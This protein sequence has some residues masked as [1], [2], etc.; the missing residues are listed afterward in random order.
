MIFTLATNLT[1]KSAVTAGWK[2]TE[3]L[4]VL[5]SVYDLKVLTMKY[6]RIRSGNV[7]SAIF[8]QNREGIEKRK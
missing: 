6:S 1:S 4:K 8:D 2:M 3:P 7:S 5:R